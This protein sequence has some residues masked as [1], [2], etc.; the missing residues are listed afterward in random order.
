LFFCRLKSYRIDRLGLSSFDIRRAEDGSAEDRSRRKKAMADKEY[1][2]LSTRRER[3]GLLAKGATGGQLDAAIHACV[4]NRLNDA[5]RRTV[6]IQTIYESWYERLMKRPR[7]PG[8]DFALTWEDVE[9]MFLDVHAIVGVPRPPPQPASSDEQSDSQSMAAPMARLRVRVPEP[10]PQRTS[11]DEK[12]ELQDIAAPMARLSVDVLAHGDDSTVLEHIRRALDE[13]PPQPALSDK[14]SGV[15]VPLR[16]RLSLTWPRA[17]RLGRE[18]VRPPSHTRPDQISIDETEHTQKRP[19]TGLILALV[20]AIVCVGGSLWMRSK[21]S[22]SINLAG[23]LEREFSRERD[24]ASAA[25]GSFTAAKEPDNIAIT[26]VLES[27]QVANSKQKQ[28]KQ[29]LDKNDISLEGRAREHAEAEQPPD[30]RQVELKQALDESEKRTLALERENAAQKQTADTKQSELKRAVA[31]E[32]ELTS[33]RETAASAEEPS[34]AEVSTRDAGSPTGSPKGPLDE[35]NA[36][37][38]IIGTMS[39]PQSKGHVIAGVQ[40]ASDATQDDASADA[41]GQFTRSNRSQLDR[42]QPPPGISPA[43]E[44]KLVA[45]AESLIKQFDFASARLLLAHALEK[46]SARSAFMMAETYDGQILRSWQAYG[47]R[48]DAQ[49]ARE[50]YQIAAAAGIEKA[51]ERAEALQSDAK[52]DRSR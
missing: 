30:A 45:R 8:A 35:S 14:K 47:V 49:K 29:A 51:R 16:A 7:P 27:E 2:E 23:S 12:S 41:S 11:C 38:E 6:L 1:D 32:P 22:S 13:P 9:R 10:P 33:S 42:P 17:R 4:D 28:F 44:A 24:R 48:G 26:E 43:E 31:L 37:S 15:A 34:N 20:A 5:E 19:I 39:I 3:V 21:D 36:A 18:L 52:F 40:T 50:F 25:I 46:G